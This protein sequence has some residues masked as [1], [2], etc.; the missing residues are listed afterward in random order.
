MI[1]ARSRPTAVFAVFAVEAVFAWM[2]AAPWAETF[3][4]TVGAHPDG[5]RA[6]FWEPGAPML[7]DVEH[8]IGGV[9]SALFAATSI[10][11]AVYALLSVLISGALIAALM[12]DPLSR[13]IGRGAETFWRMLAIG[14]TTIFASVVVFVL[15]GVL[16]AY[17]LAQRS[18]NPRI[19][20]ILAAIP[21]LLAFAVIVVIMALGDLAR[22]RVVA[23]DVSAVD[24]M[25]TSGRDRRALGSQSLAALPRYIASIGLLGYGAALTTMAKSVL[26]IFLVHQMIAVL[27]VALRAS[28][29]A[30]ALRHVGVQ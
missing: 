9:L 14:A 20:L 11:L 28:V 22:A 4:R 5:D 27:R 10:G 3:A 7:L 25:M 13:A 29:L 8:R 1:A 18:Q 26:I 21:L 6:L 15:L 2:L 24:A 23:D 17:G 30:R 16:P 12:D 19:G